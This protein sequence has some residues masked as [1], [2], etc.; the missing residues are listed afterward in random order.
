[1][2]ASGIDNSPNVVLRQRVLCL[3][4]NVISHYGR[5]APAAQAVNVRVFSPVVGDMSSC[6]Y[7]LPVYKI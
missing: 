1:M 2:P 6:S 4:P 7:S 3:R 5:E